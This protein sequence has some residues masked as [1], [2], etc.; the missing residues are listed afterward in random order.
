MIN[1]P[2]NPTLI[3]VEQAKG[4]GNEEAMALSPAESKQSVN[5]A[6]AIRLEQ[7]RKAAKESRRRKKM[8]IEGTECFWRVLTSVSL[9]TTY[10]SSRETNSHT[11]FFPTTQTNR[12]STISH[13][14]LSLQRISEATK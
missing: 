8:M 1:D 2:T 4:E 11:Y 5:K 7:N 3:K 6:R 9:V 13:L 14:L 10:F 12:T